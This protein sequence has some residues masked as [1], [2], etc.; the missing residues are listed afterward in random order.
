[1]SRFVVEFA[2]CVS[3][4]VWMD[5]VSGKKKVANLKIP[6]YWAGPKICYLKPSNFILNILGLTVE[7]PATRSP[8]V[9]GSCPPLEVN[10]T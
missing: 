6:G 5:A 2:G 3:V 9:M 10:S 4:R 8:W 7:Y 1:M